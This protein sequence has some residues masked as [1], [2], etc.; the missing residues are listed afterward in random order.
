MY[1]PKANAVQE[2]RD[3][4]SSALA[5]LVAA[6][7]LA[8]LVWARDDGIL[9]A[10]H[11]PLLYD[12]LRKVLEGHVAKANPIGKGPKRVLVIFRGPQGYMSPSWY[13]SKAEHGKEVPTWDYT[14][15]LMHGTLTAADDQAAFLPGFLNRLTDVNEAAVQAS[16]P[17]HHPWHVADAPA[18]YIASEMR[19]IVGIVIAVDA[20][21]GKFKMSQNK[22]EKDVAGVL[23]GLARQQGADSDLARM[24]AQLNGVPLP[25]AGTVFERF[26]ALAAGLGAGFAVGLSVGYLLLRSRR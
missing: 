18:E 25:A 9:V 11:I 10:D 6:H 22:P 1:C 15:A 13:P 8:T 17:T 19:A 23:E 21:A 20:V 14:V 24:V 7:P 16:D 3:D 12:P 5:E 2:P 4:G 26:G